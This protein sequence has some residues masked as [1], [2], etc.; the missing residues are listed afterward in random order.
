[1]YTEKEPIT[2]Y[3]IICFN[4]DKLNNNIINNFLYNKY[5]DIQEYNYVNIKNLN[6]IPEFYDKIKIL[7]VRRKHSLN[8]VSFIRGKYDYENLNKM[9]SLMTKNEITNIKNKSFNILWDELWGETSK[10]KQYK[11]EYNISKTKFN[12]LKNN[13]FNNLLD[14]N[15]TNFTEPEWEIP[16]GR[17]NINETPI[18]CAKREFEEETNININDVNILERVSNIDEEYIGTNMYKYKHIYYLAS[19][20]NIIKIN[21]QDYYEIGDIQWLSIPDAIKKIRP[22]YK[23]KIDVINIVYFFLINLID[24][25]I[26]SNN[27]N[28]INI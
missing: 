24:N 13:N 23:K 7:M 12:K 5:L 2:S 4:I 27:N 6:L 25:I 21:K 9:F 17:K 20:N 14:D 26:K 28:I 1:M 18:D 3:G 8:Y 15:I 11:K 22:Y 10:L 19:T 16:K